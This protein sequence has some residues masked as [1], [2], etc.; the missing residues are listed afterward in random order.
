MRHKTSNFKKNK[1]GCAINKHLVIRIYYN[2]DVKMFYSLKLVRKIQSSTANMEMC[3][4]K[5]ASKL[6]MM[7]TNLRHLRSEDLFYV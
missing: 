4:Q 6:T 3:A 1:V 2:S 5:Y 7:I